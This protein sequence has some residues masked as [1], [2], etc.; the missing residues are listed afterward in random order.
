MTSW[1]QTSVADCLPTMHKT[2]GLIAQQVQR[3][4]K[5]RLYGAQMYVPE[6]PATQ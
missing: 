5:E 3:E 1:G 6:G 2:K 4:K